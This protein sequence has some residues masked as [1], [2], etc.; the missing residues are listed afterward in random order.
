MF[1]GLITHIGTIKSVE[2][3]TLDMSIVIEAPRDFFEGML[4]GAS[5]AV[6][7]VCL[8][9]TQFDAESFSADIS[10]ETLNCTALSD[11]CEGLKVNLEPCLTLSKP[12]GGHLLNGHV[13]GTGVIRSITHDGRSQVFEVEMPRELMKYMA[14]KGTVALDG[15]SL[16]INRIRSTTV[17]I[18]CVPHT[19]EHTSFA[20]KQVGERLNIEVDLLMLYLERLLSF[21]GREDMRLLDED[22]I[23]DL[24]EMSHTEH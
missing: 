22:F 17:S 15:V 6:N 11:M 12:L 2:K 1:T 14:P 13:H 19:L 9:V 4:L 10:H 5:I 24:G 7:G 21:E 16:T 18:N 23:E 8:T 3:K 20:L